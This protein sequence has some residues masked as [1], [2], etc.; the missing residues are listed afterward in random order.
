MARGYRRR[1]RM[2][3]SSAAEGPIIAFS[4]AAQREPIVRYLAALKVMTLRM[5]SEASTTPA[6]SM[7]TSVPPM[8]ARRRRGPGQRGVV[9]GIAGLLQSREGPT[10]LAARGPGPCEAAR[11]PLIF[12]SRTHRNHAFA[13]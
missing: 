9:D 4:P 8:T 11:F 10:R 6:D 1:S 12:T 13:L 5:S 7:A 3:R 2:G